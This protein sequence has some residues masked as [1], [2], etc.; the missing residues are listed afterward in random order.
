M[1]TI[2]ALP[3]QIKQLITNLLSNA[4]K[5]TDPVVPPRIDISGCT[6]KG[7]EISAKGADEKKTY[8]KIS[9]SDNGIGFDP[10]Y[11]YKIFEL[12]QRLHNKNVYSGTGI[13]LALCKK[14]IQHHNGFITGDSEP[15]KGSV[16]KFYIPV[17]KDQKN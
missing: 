14:I 15:G 2:H 13:G 11:R 16:F 6:I 1:P 9:I 7:S 8:T 3:F 10:K 5:Y 12:F 17:M 4:L